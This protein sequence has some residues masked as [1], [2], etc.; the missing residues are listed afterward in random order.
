VLV[1]RD[2]TELAVYFA[3]AILLTIPA[4]LLVLA[5]YR[6]A[7]RRGMG[8]RAAAGGS[9][10]LAE[11]APAELPI[12][13]VGAPA[14]GRLR[15]RLVIIYVVGAL[16]AGVVLSGYFFRMY[17]VELTVGRGVLTTWTWLWP[18]AVTAAILLALP[19]R[20]TW[21]S[22]V[23]YVA[24][25]AVL[26]V[27]WSLI[28]HHLLGRLD[29]SPAEN[30]RSYLSFLLVQAG[31]PFLAML[32]T[33]NRKLRPVAPLVFAGLLLFSACSLGFYRLF[34]ALFDNPATRRIVFR[35]EA[36]EWVWPMV[37]ALPA[38]YACLAAMRLI[39]RAFHRKTFSDIQLVLDLWWV[40]AV[41]YM[42]PPLGAQSAGPAVLLA[43]LAYRVTIGA[44]LR[45]WRVPAAPG[46]RLLLL[47][48]FGFRRRSEALFDQIAQQ[49]RFLG[50]VSMIGGVDLAGR[51]IDPAEIITFLAG[52]VRSLFV[53]DPDD[54]RRRL[55]ELDDRRDPDGRFRVN[56]LYCHD[57]TWRPSLEALLARSQAVLMDLRGFNATNSGCVFE[58]HRI[59]DGG[60]L[61]RT[62]FVVDRRTDL[63]LLRETLASRLGGAEPPLNLVQ[64]EAQTQRDLR[65][66]FAALQRLAG[67][68]AA[69]TVPA[70]PQSG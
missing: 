48:V 30:L 1:G 8:A 58:L 45:L 9:E 41:F 22:S 37:T 23:G 56:E 44:G 27:L 4:S 65:G 34:L 7:V 5:W 24:G 36:I 28:S 18:T 40:I 66:L 51:T 12:D 33:S 35:A 29:V 68:L 62:L 46:P 60:R 11:T 38:G 39:G 19:P 25:G 17:Q 42:M 6:W 50:S 70:R 49:W 63:S 54:L 64:M 16:A 15:L 31:P 61:V 32:A 52:N 10:V 47:R 55:D 14:I 2:A 59:A 53:R 57:D 67:V 21:I 13:G 43:F 26:V 69:P 3:V 20:W